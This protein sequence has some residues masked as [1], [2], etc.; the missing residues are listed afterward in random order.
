VP[1]KNKQKHQMIGQ[2]K[3][4]LFCFVLFCFFVLQQTQAKPILVTQRKIRLQA[5]Q[6]SFT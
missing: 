6:E 2:K 1:H 4:Q 5:G 3:N